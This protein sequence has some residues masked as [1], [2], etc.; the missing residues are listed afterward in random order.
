MASITNQNS[1]YK[2]TMLLAAS[3]VIIAAIMAAKTIVVPILLALF[4]SIICIQPILFLE[5]LKIPFQLAMILVLAS[6][7]FSLFILLGFAGNSFA[8]FLRDL[9]LY[10]GKLQEMVVDLISKL[11]ENGAKLNAEQFIELIDPAEILNFTA[12]AAGE[13]GKMLSDSFI[14]IFI[15]I[16][17]LLETKSFMLKFKLLENIFGSSLEYLNTITVSIRHYLSIKTYVSIV[18]GL[19][20]WL[21]LYLIGVQY[22]VLWG[23]IAF[24]LNYIPNIGSLLA[25]I[26]TMI[27]SLTQMGFEG[28]LWTG[29]CYVVV[30]IVMGSMVEP[31]VMGKGLGLSTLVVF[32]ALIIWGFILGTVGMFLSIPLTITIKII[33]EQNDRTKWI[34]VLLGSEKETKHLLNET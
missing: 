32:L 24:L 29:L 33:L 26:P 5:K 13:M 16:F 28:M 9:P 23:A 17:I 6:L 11:N 20:I 12:V 3:I 22:A 25:A 1:G 31:K 8:E 21:W 15:M 19:I 30:N 18:T 34:A 4:L 27:F 7:G 10:E 14:I 2:N